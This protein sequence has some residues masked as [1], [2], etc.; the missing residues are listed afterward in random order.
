MISKLPD[1]ELISSLSEQ[2]KLAG[3]VNVALLES[4]RRAVGLYKGSL[5]DVGP[6]MDKVGVT[7]L[8]EQMKLAA[9]AKS[10]QSAVGVHKDSL[11]HLGILAESVKMTALTEQAKLLG[12]VGAAWAE[13]AK[14]VGSLGAAFAESTQWAVGVDKNSLAH[15]GA[16][17]DSMRTAAFSGVSAQQQ[18]QGLLAGLSEQVRAITA[19]PPAVAGFQQNVQAMAQMLSSPFPTHLFEG[20]KCGQEAWLGTASVIED[21][22]RRQ[23]MVE[24]YLAQLLR[25]QATYYQTWLDGEHDAFTEEFV[26]YASGLF[27]HAW[28]M[29]HN[30]DDANDAVQDTYEKALRA[31]KTYPVGRVR[32]LNVSAWLHRILT[33]TVLNFLRDRRRCEP[34]EANWMERQSGSRFDQPEAV[35]VRQELLQILYDSFRDLPEIQHKIIFMHYLGAGVIY[36]KN[37]AV[38]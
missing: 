34:Y 19:L 17:V 26:S 20:L 9:F 24:P 22:V 33:R 7:A 38:S 4:A 15:V 28:S 25:E 37:L 27:L 12:S 36:P 1:A 10:A 8:G 2:A 32:R 16:L 13:Q 35:L 23:G 29:L 11:A 5:L 6:L 3:T 30:V 21:F 14:L 18:V 31:L